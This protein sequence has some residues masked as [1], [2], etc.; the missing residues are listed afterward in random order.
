MI[1]SDL[2]LRQGEAINNFSKTL[3]DP[4]SDLVKETL[5]DP[6]I[7]DFITIAQPFTER[8]LETELVKH[9]ERFLLELGVEGHCRVKYL[10][11]K[12][13]YSLLLQVQGSQFQ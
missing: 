5:K 13:G 11:E 8:E 2:H 7:F 1:K 6:Y 9:V 10:H 4:Q 3:P 12:E